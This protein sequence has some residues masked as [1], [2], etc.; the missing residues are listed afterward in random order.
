MYEAYTK[1][2][3][4]KK[5]E[6]MSTL[7]YIVEFKQLNK[8]CTNLKID[9]DALLAVELFYN[10]NLTEHEKPLALTACPQMKYETMKNI[11][12]RIFS[13]AKTEL[14]INNKVEIKEEMMITENCGRDMKLFRGFLYR[15]AR[16]KG[17]S[18]TIGRGFKRMNLVLNGVISRGNVCE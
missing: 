10:A 6:V 8:K 1:F 2:D 15:G 7:N 3:S 18:R 4:F 11:L 16:Y 12:T 9:L 5:T 14:Q 17:C 13:T